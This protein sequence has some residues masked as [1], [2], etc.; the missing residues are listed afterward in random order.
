[1][2]STQTAPAHP[3]AGAIYRNTSLSTL[4]MVDG[5]VKRV[6]KPGETL[7]GENVEAKIRPLLAQFVSAGEV[8]RIA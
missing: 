6:M 2:T 1:M 5:D 4:I 8:E 3:D 7:R